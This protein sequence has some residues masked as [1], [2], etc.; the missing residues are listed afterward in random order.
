MRLC[1]VVSHPL[2]QVG[3][4]LLFV[5]TTQKGEM[6]LLYTEKVRKL[7][8]IAMLIALEILL[9]RFFSIATMTVKIGF[10]F[11]PI[12]VIAIC[13]GPLAAGFGYAIADYIGATLF[14]IGPYFPGF[15]VTCF[16]CGIAYGIF[17]YRPGRTL[18]WPSVILAVITVLSLQLLLDTMWVVMLTGKGY[19]AVLPERVL[20]VVVM[21]PVQILCIQMVQRRVLP[22][23][24]KN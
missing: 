1:G 23:V 24:W 22:L 11:L 6:F 8:T 15:T 14:P 21:L 19:I 13:Y 10:S 9:S 18:G 12:A 2:P 16:F 5:A 4:F 20:K 3:K 7:T 17:L